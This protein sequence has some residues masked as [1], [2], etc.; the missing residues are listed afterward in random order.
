MSLPVV[1]LPRAKADLQQ[2]LRWWSENRSAVQALR[3]YNGI[4]EAIAGLQDNPQRCALAR[5]NDRS[6][7]ELRE[8]SFGLGSRPTHR[9]IFVIDPGAVHVLAIRHTARDDWQP[10]RK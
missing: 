6:D 3:W 1:I 4:H 2:A 8:L 9:I 10:K 5:E 7:D